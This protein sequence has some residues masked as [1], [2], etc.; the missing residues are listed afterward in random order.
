[1]QTVEGNGKIRRD[2]ITTETLRDKNGP[3]TH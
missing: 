1:M 2:P 3:R